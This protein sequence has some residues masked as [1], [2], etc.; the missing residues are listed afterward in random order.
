MEQKF[1]LVLGLLWQIVK[2][3]LLKEVNLKAHPQLIRLL[4][5]GEQLS[6]LLKLSPEDLLLRWFNYHLTNA[7]YEKKITN[8]SGDVQDGEK[9]TILLNQLNSQ[10]CDKSALNDSDLT[11][12]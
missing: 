7:G 8:F 4:K 11:T 1:A 12:R 3:V 5:D 2:M 10:L 6:D 9:Y